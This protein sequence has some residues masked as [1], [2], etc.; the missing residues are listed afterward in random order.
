MKEEKIYPKGII[1]FPKREGS[2]DFVLGSAV[3]TVKDFFEFCKENQS[4]MSEYNGKNQLK[5]NILQGQN[6]V[7]F[8]VDTYKKK[9]EPQEL[10][11]D[12]FSDDLPFG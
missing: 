4:L 1:T 11:K 6:G 2:P 5:L 10:K 9:Q 12:I 3:V 7:Y 8:T